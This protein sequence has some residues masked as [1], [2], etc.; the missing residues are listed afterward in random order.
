[1]VKDRGIVDF[2]QALGMFAVDGANVPCVITDRGATFFSTFV[3][4]LVQVQF[5]FVKSPQSGRLGAVVGWQP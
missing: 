5:A 4:R 3:P 2:N 1:M